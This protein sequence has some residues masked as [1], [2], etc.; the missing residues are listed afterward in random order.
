MPLPSSVCIGIGEAAVWTVV[1]RVAA[2]DVT[3]QVIDAIRIDAEE[4][5][6]RIAEFTLRP[7]AATVIDP[8]SWTGR[9]VEID[10][11]DNSTGT[12]TDAVRRFTDEANRLY[13][14]MNTCRACATRPAT[15][16]SMR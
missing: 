9:A 1:V 11:A 5:A 4:G 2:V 15:L 10:V 7:P 13:G 3:A 8:A 16:R 12:P 6:A 14:V